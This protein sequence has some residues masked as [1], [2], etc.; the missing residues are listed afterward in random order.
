M[1]ITHK[2]TNRHAAYRCP[3]PRSVYDRMARTGSPIGIRL[4][5][6]QINAIEDLWVRAC[7]PDDDPLRLGLP[8]RCNKEWFC[9]IFCGGEGIDRDSDSSIW[10]LIQSFNMYDPLALLASIPQIRHRY[11][12]G[13]V[14]T[15]LGVKHVVIGTS[16]K[17]HGVRED[18]ASELANF[19]YNRC[20]VE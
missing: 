5:R 6:S 11:F 17:N 20:V 15:V 7:R 10:D 12:S 19:M 13:D 1:N 16:Q 18:K 8:P 9:N 14:K 4:Q 2:P 3:M